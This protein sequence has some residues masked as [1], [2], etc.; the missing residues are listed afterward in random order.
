MDNKQ[1]MGKICP[2]C[3]VEGKAY[4]GEHKTAVRN[5]KLQRTTIFG[6][7]TVI[8]VGWR[9]WNCGYE[10]GFEIDDR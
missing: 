10:W 2:K 7:T 1:E 8:D 3:G 9:C 5:I 6:S 4:H